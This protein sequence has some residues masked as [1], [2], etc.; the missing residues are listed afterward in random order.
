MANIELRLNDYDQILD[1][2]FMDQIR[3]MNKVGIISFG[4]ES[5]YHMLPDDETLTNVLNALDGFQKKLILPTAF[6][7]YFDK[8]VHVLD[9]AIDHVDIVSINDY[10]VLHYYRE[11]Y[12]DRDV[13]VCL[14]NGLSYTYD[15]CPWNEHFRLDEIEEVQENIL[16]SNLDGMGTYEWLKDTFPFNFDIEIPAMPGVLKSANNMKNQGHTVS[17]LV[18]EVPVSFSRACHAIRH[19][20]YTHDNCERVCRK[21]VKLEIDQRWDFFEGDVVTVQEENRKWIPNYLVFGTVI[22]LEEKPKLQELDVK[23]ADQYIIDYKFYEN[24]GQVEQMIGQLPA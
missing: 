8:V 12:K 5:C 11:K 3:Q 13:T 22:H 15:E 14:G 18:D 6:E 9:Q 24:M 7:S 19:F 21:K 1:G 16:M 10:G 17:L 23:V 4:S 20:D 2:A